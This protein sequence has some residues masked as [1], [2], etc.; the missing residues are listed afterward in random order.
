MLIYNYPSVR[1]SAAITATRDKTDIKIMFG[2]NLQLEL[3]Y[4]DTFFWKTY[5]QGMTAVIQF[6]SRNNKNEPF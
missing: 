1:L 4:M 3:Y 5:F 2:G 6:F